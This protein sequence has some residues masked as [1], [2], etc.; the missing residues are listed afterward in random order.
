[1]V[2][3]YL[4]IEYCRKQNAIIT[5]RQANYDDSPTVKDKLI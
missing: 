1:M 3:Y 5:E 4:D 2:K